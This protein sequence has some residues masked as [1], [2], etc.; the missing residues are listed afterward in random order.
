MADI[1]E[2]TA[3]GEYAA[4]T[5]ALSLDGTSLRIAFGRKGNHGAVFHGAAIL[6]AEA[7]KDLRDQ[8]QRLGI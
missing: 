6:T 2:V 5:V 7:I 3:A 8:L 4:T 1:P